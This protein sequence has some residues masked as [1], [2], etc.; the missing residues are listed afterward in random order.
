MSKLQR[1]DK[2]TPRASKY[3]LQEYKVHTKRSIILL[4]TTD[5]KLQ[6]KKHSFIYNTFTVGTRRRTEWKEKG[7]RAGSICRN[8]KTKRNGSK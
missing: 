3:M 7:K 8:Y 4:C 5:E 2:Q 1:I 6:F